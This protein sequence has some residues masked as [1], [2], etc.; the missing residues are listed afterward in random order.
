MSF[1][2]L[3]KAVITVSI[4]QRLEKIWSKN[5]QRP[6]FVFQDTSFILDERWIRQLMSVL[7]ITSCPWFELN[8]MVWSWFCAAVEPIS[9]VKYIFQVF[10]MLLAVCSSLCAFSVAQGSWFR[11]HCSMHSVESFFFIFNMSRCK[12]WESYII[13]IRPKDDQ[14]MQKRENLWRGVG[15][16]AMWTWP[17]P[18]LM[19]LCIYLV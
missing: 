7:R 5:R 16:M 14:N 8:V 11:M 13:S 12:Q 3:Q 6:T 10:V 18:D 15:R 1:L 17:S 19:V 9:K 2:Q 4:S